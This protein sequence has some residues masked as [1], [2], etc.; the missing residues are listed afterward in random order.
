[1]QN[2][3]L[4]RFTPKEPKFVDLLKQV[5]AISIEAASL[6][7][8]ALKT[9]TQEER[10]DYFHKI[11]DKEHEADVIANQIF[12]ALESCFITPFDREDIS[13]LSNRLDDVV[14]YINGSSKR[15]AIYN[16]YKIH[17]AIIKLSDLVIA[18]VRAIDKGINMLATLRSDKK[19]LKEIVNSLHALENDADE[20]YEMAIRE[21]FAQ[22][23][24]AIEL[25]KTKELLS[26]LEKTTDAIACW[27]DIEDYYR[28]IRIKLW[29]S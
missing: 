6:L 8:E 29:Y 25:M 9:K 3:I 18:G 10:L 2:S 16:P 12:E 21:V 5:S 7:G 4:S 13:E 14:D 22:E 26:E 17:P 11:K 1:M 24:N 23:K 15:M 28:K 27:Q 20:V 19:A